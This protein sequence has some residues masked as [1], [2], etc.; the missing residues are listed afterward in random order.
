ML[1]PTTSLTQPSPASRE[2]VSVMIGLLMRAVAGC[3]SSLSSP[4]VGAST[5]TG[6]SNRSGSNSPLPQRSGEDASDEM[7]GGGA[8][9]SHQPGHVWLRAV[10]RRVRR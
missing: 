2:I 5:T 1:I 8:D 4:T 3:V 9:T 6:V 10:R 7:G